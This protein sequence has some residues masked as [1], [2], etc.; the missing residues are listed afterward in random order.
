MKHPKRKILYILLL[1]VLL[2]AVYIL[3]LVAQN[4]AEIRLGSRE[5]EA[6]KTEAISSA[7]ENVG[8]AWK[9]AEA[10][11]E[12]FY[13]VNTSLSDFAGYDVLEKTGNQSADTTALVEEIVNFRGIMLRPEAVCGGYALLVT[14]DPVSSTGCHI[15]YK[16]DLIAG[17]SDLESAGLTWDAIRQNVGSEKYGLKLR[18]TTYE[19]AVC[20]IPEMN[21]YLVMLTPKVNIPAA[22]DALRPASESSKTT[23][24]DGSTPSLSAAVR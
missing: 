3:I 11:I 12:E 9:E 1:T 6:L 23:Q 19:L 14:E 7:A 10:K 20:E 5:A 18:D 21:G 17:E 2:I 16:N 8:I 22:L 4:A 15:V 13:L 24:A